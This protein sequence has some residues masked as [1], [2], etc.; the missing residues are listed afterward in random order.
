MKMRKALAILLAGTM[1][2]GMTGG[3]LS[4]YAEE[5]TETPLVLACDEMSEKFS[6][7]FANS[8]PD[9]NVADMTAVSLLDNT[10]AGAIIYNGIEG[11]TE[12][13]NGIDYTYEGIADCVVTENEDGTVNYDF[14]LREGVK[15]S[16]GEE[17]T[18][19]DVIFSYYVYCDPSYDGGTSTY[20]LPIVGMEE[21]RSGAEALYSVMLANGAENTDFSLYTEEQQ[22][23]FFETDLPA[24]EEAFAQSIVDYVAANYA[25]Y[26]TI[27][28]PVADGMALW[29]YAEENEDGSITGPYTGTTWTM[30]DGD[31]PT[32]ADYW[33]EIIANPSFEGDIALASDTEAASDG[34]FSYLDETYLNTVETGNSAASIAG[35]EK[36]GDYSVRVT[37]S[38]KNATAI[39]QLA[40][41]VQPMHYYG[42]EALYD[43]DNN[44]FGFVKGDLST[45]RA[46]T[47]EPMGA[48]PY[49]FVKFEN[50]VVYMEANEYYWK[51]EPKTKYL[52]FK[53]TQEADKL[54]AVVQGTVDASEPAISKE[55]LANIKAENSNGEMDGDKLTV[56]L[57]D[58]NGYGYIGINARNVSVNGESGSD[59][60]KNLRKAI[61]TVLSVYRDVAIDSYYGEAA[62]VINYPI[63]NTSWAAPQKSDADYAVAFSTDVEG[64]PIYTDEMSEDEKYAAA[65]DAALGFFE[66]AGYTVED[67]KVTAAPEGAK[68]EYELMIPAGG[69]GDHPSIGVV[70]SASEA[71]ATIGFTLNIN[72]LSDSSLLWAACEAN[73]AELWC[74]AWSATLDPDM[75]QVYHSEGGSAYMYTIY[76][77]E[78]DALVMEGRTTTDQAVRKAIYKEAL[79]FVVDYAVEVPIYQRQESHLFSVER[80][81]VDTIAAD[82]TSFYSWLKEIEKVEMN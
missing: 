66:A 33:T 36:T 14:T 47:T 67:G 77:E 43:Y 22:K 59:A 16:D 4:V 63:S 23:A 64:N 35:I 3:V 68:M 6:E 39:Y 30:T 71:L 76:D 82:Q 5:T 34:L 61:A 57:T 10:R 11:E 31:C 70:T 51:G 13:W 60:S 75:F 32:A 9:Q 80:I 58:Y 18:A 65:L 52:Q 25:D 19:D 20:S 48:G 56:A 49:K 12:S 21:Y 69:S 79:D 72:D 26:C 42:D 44:S 27:G 40:I 17:L 37:L 81:N 28:D 29:G 50:K 55:V 7:F 41:P 1:V 53:T 38:E 8:V 45:V 62:S 15:F 24:A 78:L 54:T 46:K 73:T 2:S 74:A